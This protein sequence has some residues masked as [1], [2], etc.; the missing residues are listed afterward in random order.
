VF[1]GTQK[2]RVDGAAD[3]VAGVARSKLPFWL[4][5]VQGVSEPVA[6][7]REVQLIGLAR[8]LVRDGFEPTTIEAVTEIDK[9]AEVLGRA[10]EDA[11]VVLGLAPT[12]PWVFPY[13]D[14]PT[15]SL[16]GEPR[17]VPIKPL[18]RVVVTTTAKTLP[19]K[20]TRRTIVFRRQK[21]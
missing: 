5:A 11:I 20:A 12:D 10:N 9:G 2:W 1:S 3:A 17:I 18:E 13:T 19:P 14:G 8:R 4:L 15:W 21:R 16:E 6:L 7:R